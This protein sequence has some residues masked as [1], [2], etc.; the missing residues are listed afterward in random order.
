MSS[1][2]MYIPLDGLTTGAIRSGGNPEARQSAVLAAPFDDLL[3]HSGTPYGPTE[4]PQTDEAPSEAPQWLLKAG[5][6]A[7]GGGST[8]AAPTPSWQ[9]PPMC[10]LASRGGAAAVN[11]GVLYAAMPAERAL[12]ELT[13]VDY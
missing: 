7:G 10:P 12:N 2:S 4:W 1:E 8:P 3:V 11:I 6:G 5:H 13:R 9:P